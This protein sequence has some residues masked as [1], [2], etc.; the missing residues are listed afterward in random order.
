MHYLPSLP[1]PLP[2]GPFSLLPPPLF[3]PPS[4]LASLLASPPSICSSSPHQVMYKT[5]VSILSNPKIN[6][7][8]TLVEKEM[9]LN[10]ATLLAQSVEEI[11]QF[12][13]ENIDPGQY[14]QWVD[15]YQAQL[16]VLSSQIAWSSSVEAA[17]Q[18]LLN[19]SPPHDMTPL[20]NTL[21]IVESTLNVLAD[22]VLQ[23]QPPVRRRKLE[24]L[25]GCFVLDHVT[26]C[27]MMLHILGIDSNGH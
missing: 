3:P 26:V 2:L 13:S 15:R 6:Q 19:Q 10:L 25:V 12:D 20:Q 27:N 22:S 9:R 4:L 5:P 18:T 7:W 14:L 17:L 21:K 1:P 8:L 23:E 11:T 24:H 16:V